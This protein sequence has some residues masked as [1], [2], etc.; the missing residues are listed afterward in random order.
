MKR[1]SRLKN[2]GNGLKKKSTIKKK[3]KPRNKVK[4]R[5]KVSS[6]LW[7]EIKKTDQVFSLLVRVMAADQDGMVKCYTC[8]RVAFWKQDG[9]EC[10]HFRPRGNMGTRW[11]I[12]NCKPQDIGCNRLRNGNLKVFETNLKKEYGDNIIKELNQQ[13]EKVV[14]FTVDKVKD[15]R[16]NFTRQLEQLRK[17]KGL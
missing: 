10:G 7:R 16:Y 17:E 11:S 5:K 13:A 14:R 6:P 3:H 8:D 1:T 15:M 2:N 9:M 12:K 4:E